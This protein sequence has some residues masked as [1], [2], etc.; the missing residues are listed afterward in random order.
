M[1]LFRAKV[2]DEPVNIR[3][4]E[5]PPTLQPWLG[6]LQ[7]PHAGLDLLLGARNRPQTDVVEVAVEI[8]YAH[9]LAKA[10]AQLAGVV[11]VLDVI[12]GDIFGHVDLLV[13]VQQ[14]LWVAA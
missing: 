14:H 3:G 2:L 4:V 11:K 10:H 12:S 9:A 8:R 1:A 7:S 6:S 5:L 13:H